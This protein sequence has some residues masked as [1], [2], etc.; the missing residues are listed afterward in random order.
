MSRALQRAKEIRDSVRDSAPSYQAF[1]ERIALYT[2]T[3]RQALLNHVVFADGSK[4]KPIHWQ[5]RKLIESTCQ[6][7]ERYVV[8]FSYANGNT[9]TIEKKD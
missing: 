3:L 9:P 7:L 2:D 8:I 6:Y 4:P 1:L 5:K